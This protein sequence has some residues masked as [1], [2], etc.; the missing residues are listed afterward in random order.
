LR[1][2]R[3]RCRVLTCPRRTFSEAVPAFLPPRVQ[4]TPRFTQALATLGF[5][6]GGE[7]GARLARQ[8]RLPSSG[9]TLLRVLR[10]TALPPR[11]TPRVLGVDDFAFRRR[12]VYGTVLIDLER[13]W[14]VEILPDRTAE[15]FT[16]WLRTHPGVEIIARDRASDYATG[17]RAGAPTAHQVADR[18]HLLCNLTDALVRY[19]QRITPELR[20][21]LAA[22]PPRPSEDPPGTEDRPTAA[23]PPTEPA[24]PTP[25]PATAPGAGESRPLPR[26]GR[27][28]HSAG[29]HATR[30]AN[31]AGLFTLVK[32]RYSSGH[33]LQ[34]IAQE[35]GVST[36]TLRTWVRSAEVPVDQRGYCGPSKIDA[37][38]PYLRERLAAGCTN[39]TRLW[40]EIRQ[41]GFTGTR[42]LVAKW[43][44]AHGTQ[45]AAPSA[46]PRLPTAKALT[47]LVLQP[48]AMPSA[49]ERQLCQQL[50]QHPELQ[51]VG[52]LIRDFGQLLRERRGAELDG[53]LARASRSSSPEVRNVAAGI[54][55]D[56]AAVQAAFESPWS[57]GP[58][59]GQ[60]H[61]LKLIKRTGYGRAKFD[62][63]RL[64]VLYAG[65]N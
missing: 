32:L 50:Q 12:R 60:V 13:R 39:Q 65:E 6:V 37:Y 26:Y 1:V 47:W 21:L 53:W 49:S 51:E 48:P 59:E 16:A 54:T 17:A 14:P 46:P 52:A 20:R 25:A 29:T 2:R 45:P 36:R 31:R 64:R 15:S 28:P 35:T 11:P 23:L 41:Q 24:A 27:P 22:D 30:V 56:Y 34:Q 33:S 55:R 9:D 40:Q 3:F 57:S 8:L 5:A 4:R 61:R 7:A 38:L 10:A 43:I 44:H 42:S 18:W 63:L 58:V 62:L 19:I